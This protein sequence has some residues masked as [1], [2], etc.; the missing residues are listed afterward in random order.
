M[1][2]TRTVRVTPAGMGY[3]IVCQS[4]YCCLLSVRVLP[5]VVC[6]SRVPGHLTPHSIT[7]LD[8]CVDMNGHLH[9]SEQVAAGEREEEEG[10]SGTESTLL[11]YLPTAH[12]TSAEDHYLAELTAYTKKQF[13]QV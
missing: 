4:Q 7:S 1:D 5:S 11:S 10:Q 8:E 6:Q 12:Y 9:L 2:S 13:F 3:D